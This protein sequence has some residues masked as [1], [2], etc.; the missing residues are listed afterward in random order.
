MKGYWILSKAFSASIERILWLF[1][2]ASVYVLYYVYGF[3]YV[4]PSLHPWN[5]TDLVMLYDL[6]DVLLNLF[7]SILLRIFASIFIKAIGL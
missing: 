6:F 7:A 3:T 1:V 4:E 2:L 5:E